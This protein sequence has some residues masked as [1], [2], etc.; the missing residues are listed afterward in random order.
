MAKVANAKQTGKR[1][2]EH[3]RIS[4]FDATQP[5]RLPT[6]EIFAQAMA[7]GAV[8]SEAYMMAIGA[9][10]GAKLSTARTNGCKLANREDVKQRIAWLKH[11]EAL[12]FDINETTLTKHMLEIMDGAKKA[13]DWAAARAALADVA[14]LH[15]LMI[16]RS[17]VNGTVRHIG[18]L[19]LDALKQLMDR[20]TA[21]GD[22]QPR[23]MIDAEAVDVSGNRKDR[24]ALSH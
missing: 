5:L 21:G 13:G 3:W 4:S 6:H 14:K 7:A 19:H 23:A 20:S 10:T 9:E 11:R 18:E 8:Q 12:A 2:K 15:G 1:T 22:N 24:K 16:E 17:E